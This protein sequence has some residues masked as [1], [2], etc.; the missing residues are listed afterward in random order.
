MAVPL[1]V[2]TR[3]DRLESAQKRITEARLKDRALQAARRAAQ[4]EKNSRR[5]VL[6]ELS[7]EIFAWR[8]AVV[9]SRDGL[10]LWSI[11]GGACVPVYSGWFWDGL[12]IA[13]D[14]P[15]VA[16]TRVSLDGPNHHFL[17]EEWRDD[18][19]YR[20]VGRPTSPLQL[21]DMAHPKLIEQMQTCLSGP[22]CWQSI[23]D[24]LDRR[25]ERYHQG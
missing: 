11:L 21:L 24:E 4:E 14:N 16:C 9:K 20:E 6:L 25:L 17:I 8:D 2:T 5:S 23:T 19:P 10:R 22:E 7:L 12:P 18:A 3:I 1:N 15:I 13:D